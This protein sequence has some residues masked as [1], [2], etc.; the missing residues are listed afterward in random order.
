M[1]YVN[2]LATVARGVTVTINGITIGEILD[3]GIPQPQTT[4]DDIETTN[5]DSGDWKEYVSGRKDG[6]E[7]EIKCHAIPGDEGQ[8][9]LAAR[10]A[11]GALSL[12]ITAFPSGA[13]QSFYGTI[14]TF[15]TKVEGQLLVVSSKIKVSGEPTF[16]TTASTLTAPFFVCE[17]SS[18]VFPDASGNVYTYIVNFGTG[19]E[20]T[21][22]T[23]TATAGTIQVDGV[24][25]ATG[26]ASDAITLTAGE[27]VE[28]TITVKETSKTHTVYKLLLCR[29]SS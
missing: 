24:T 16:S 2:S 6:G 22:I 23:P 14:K 28:A 3:D 15:D 21:T 11:D 8:V 26:E 5:Q 19:T 29:A 1:T 12:I 20:T 9:E 10:S 4:T 17:N 7:C 18:S 27:I 25:V 13:A